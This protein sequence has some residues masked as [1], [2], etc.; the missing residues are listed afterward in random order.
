MLIHKVVLACLLGT[1]WAAAWQAAPNEKEEA[2]LTAAR[3]GDAAKVKALVES[4]VPVDCKNRYG[5]TPL[6]YAAW[7]GSEEVVRYLIGKG[8]DV[9]VRDTF[10]KMNALGTAISKNNEGAAR[11]LVEAGAAGS[12]A[13]LGMAASNG[14]KALVAAILE[15]TK[16]NEAQLRNAV[17]SAQDKNFPEIVEILRKA[18]APEPRKLGV[19]IAPDKLARLVGT[20]SGQGVGEA[21]VE[22]KDGKLILKVGG[23]PREMLAYDELNFA[24][25]S[26]SGMSFEFVVEGEKAKSM[27]LSGNGMNAVLNRVEGK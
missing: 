9:N 8:A 3:Q 27:K 14:H 13:M 1:G 10:Y 21:A 7:G 4:G 24:V 22:L 5:I 26:M 16:P 6:F 18:G 12:D 25:P 11:A 15:K 17:Q 20:Y 19:Q 2:L 23:E